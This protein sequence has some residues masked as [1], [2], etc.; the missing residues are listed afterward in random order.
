MPRGPIDADQVEQ[1]RRDGFVLVPG[2]FAKEEID[3]LG[4]SARADKAMEDHAFGRADGEGGVVRLSLWNH[5][6][7][8]IYGLVARCRSLVDSRSEERRVGKECR[9]RGSPCHEQK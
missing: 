5:P 1:Y 6:G 9:S 4:R 3:L 7:E 8:G 2:M